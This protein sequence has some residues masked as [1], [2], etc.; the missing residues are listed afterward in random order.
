M[1]KEARVT[2]EQ[3]SCRRL[4]TLGL[5]LSIRSLIC[6]SEFV[7]SRRTAL[8]AM[9]SFIKA[10]RED[11]FCLAKVLGLNSDQTLVKKELISLLQGEMKKRMEILEQDS[12]P[13]EDAPILP[14]IGGSSGDAPPP[15]NERKSDGGEGSDD[16][17]E[18][19]DEDPEQDPIEPEDDEEF[20]IHIFME[21]LRGEYL[22]TAP[23][24]TNFRNR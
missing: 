21:N 7:S 14:V 8:V 6:N 24:A 3:S 20:L 17:H 5:I 10:N 23:Q 18:E 13:P 1:G 22:C 2:A 19:L 16:D 9:A 15:P 12:A 11:L 4:I